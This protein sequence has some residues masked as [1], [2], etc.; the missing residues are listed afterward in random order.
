M[1]FNY[2]NNKIKEFL[3]SLY[4]YKEKQVSF[5]DLIPERY[6]R[7]EYLIEKLKSK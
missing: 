5:T 1:S 7:K 4:L 2:E 3:F 6:T